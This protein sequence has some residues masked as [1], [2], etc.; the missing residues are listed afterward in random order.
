MP[1]NCE[2]STMFSSADKYLN[3][4]CSLFLSNPIL[5]WTYKSMQPCG[6]CA[7]QHDHESVVISEIFNKGSSRCD[8][9]HILGVAKLQPRPYF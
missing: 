6:M 4:E 2:M 8:H 9:A 1:K 7:V 5:F 3:T